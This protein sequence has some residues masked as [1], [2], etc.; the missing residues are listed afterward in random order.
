MISINK[1]NAPGNPFAMTDE[2]GTQRLHHW[3]GKDRQADINEL[4]NA[5]AATGQLFDNG[6]AIVRL[7]GDGQLVNVNRDGL[8][9]FIGQHIAAVRV[10]KNGSGWRKEYYTYGFAPRPRPA[11]PTMANP[12]PGA[13]TVLH[14][15]D[16][17]ALDEIYRHELLWRLP[18]VEQ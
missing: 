16:D 12:N 4:A 5:V 6:G 7:G 18:R 14:E 8:R 3:R 10:V 17:K 2:L 15:P 1:N 13:G 11:S 9:E